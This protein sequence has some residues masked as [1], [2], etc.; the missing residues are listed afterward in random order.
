MSITPLNTILSWYETGDFPTQQQFAASWSSFYHKDEFIPMDKVQDLNTKLQN[1]TDKL[2]YEAHLTNGDA[3]MTTLAKLDASNL[4][5][6]NIQAW[7]TVL[8]VGELPPNIATVDDSVNN[9]YGNV[10][11]KDQIHNLYMAMADY[12]LNG[13]IRADK[14]EA[15][16][17]TEL[18]TVTETSLAAFMANNANYTYEK[19]DMIAIPDGAG[20]HSLYIYKG[21]TKT[22]AN[23]YIATGLTN[24][25][26]AMVQGLQAALD[27]KVNKPA[28]NGNYFI[29]QSGTTTTFKSINPAANYLLFW[30]NTDFVQSDI[31][32]NAGKY[33]WGT[34]TPS[35]TLHLNNGRIRA[36]AMVFDDNPESLPYQITHTNRRFWGADLTGAPRMFMYRDFSDYKTLWEGFTDAQKTEIKTIANG[37]WSTGTI[38]VAIMTPP[39]VD[40]QNKNYWVSLRG[41]NLNLNPTSFS[42]KLMANDGIT[43]IATIPNS[44]VQLSTSGIDLTFYYNYKDLA[45]GQYKIKLWNGIAE[46]ITSLTISV[47]NQLDIVDTSTLTWTKKIYNDASNPNTFGNGSSAIYQSDSNIKPS[48][49]SD[50]TIVGALK[51]S[52]LNNVGENFYLEFLV[53]YQH[54]A[55][56]T[57]RTQYVGLM[58][59]ASAVDL[60]DQTITK[61][62]AIGQLGNSVGYRSYYLNNVMVGN[63][64]AGS[65]SGSNETINIVIIKNG[66][67]M[68][69]AVT[70]RGVTYQVVISTP[71]IE[72]SLNMAVNNMGGAATTS[73]NVSNLY[74]F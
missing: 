73:I 18:I 5:D 13:K 17:L 10:Y 4:N 64:A 42:V 26:I 38:S 52:K 51:S 22:N 59:N 20:N 16:G 40:K 45:L 72:Y 27:G 43:E 2:V 58:N 66:T 23:N 21:G 24:I 56:M 11:S 34:T 44:Q 62:K 63:L 71:D 19:N 29:N 37:G 15:L 33:G 70:A 61:I 48:S 49:T 14:I 8:G 3:H 30:N 1:K 32:N 6:V 57:D 67:S 25:T 12:V 36:K 60:L 55:N 53:N 54:V 31:Y 41:A 7:K 9:I 28:V 69:I 47:V 74:K 68:T 65:V 35:E 46:Y 39:V 50:V